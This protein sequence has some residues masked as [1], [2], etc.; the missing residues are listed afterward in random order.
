[1]A[2]A[3]RFRKTLRNIVKRMRKLGRTDVR[4]YQ[5][6]RAAEVIEK[7][8]SVA[9]ASWKLAEG[10]AITRPTERCAFLRI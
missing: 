6:K 8:F 5:G 10:V 7:L 9:D 3:P 4:S 1:V 2:Q